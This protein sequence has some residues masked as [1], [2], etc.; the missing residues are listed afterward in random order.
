MLKQLLKNFITRAA[1]S[2]GWDLVLLP[3]IYKKELLLLKRIWAFGIPATSLVPVI[4]PTEF[5]CNGLVEKSETELVINILNH[6]QTTSQLINFY[7]VGANSGYYGILAAYLGKGKINTYS[8]EPLSEYTEMIKE[9]V[10]MNELDAKS[11]NI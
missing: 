7:D 4:S 6:L 1:Q 5:F 8:F 3:K 9:T 11:K 2:F 10:I